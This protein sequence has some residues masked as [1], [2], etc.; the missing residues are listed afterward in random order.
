VE[1]DTW[2]PRENLKNTR[3]LVKRFE[4]EYREN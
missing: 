4:K 1:E 2:K 3:N